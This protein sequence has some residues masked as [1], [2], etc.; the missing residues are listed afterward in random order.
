M[1]MAF[2]IPISLL[3]NDHKIKIKKELTLIETLKPWFNKNNFQKPTEINFYH[4]DTQRNE[5]LLP[6]YKAGEIFGTKIINKRKIYKQVMP[7]T[8]KAELYDYQKKVVEKALEHYNDHGGAFFNVFCA[9]GKTV[10][11][12]HMSSLFSQT[13]GLRT[14][15][16][17][18]LIFIGKSWIGTF[19]NLTNANVYV[20]GETPGPIM[21]HHQV[22]LSMEGR[23]LNIP[24]EVLATIGHFIIDEAHTACT[25]NKVEMLLSVE[26]LFI[27]LLSATAERD[28]GYH[29]MLDMLVGPKKITKISNKPFFVFKIPT[30]Y[31]VEPKTTK[32]GVDWNDLIDQFDELP[33]RNNLIL[34]LVLNN[35][36][37]KI[38]IAFKH[39]SSA[40]RFHSWLGSYLTQHGLKSSLLVG[41]TKSY[42]DANVIVA[43]ISKIGIGFDE[44]E[45]CSNWNGR[46]INMLILPNSI[47][48]NEQVYGRVMRS[49]L[50]LV[51]EFYDKNRN[52]RNQFNKKKK[53]IESRNGKILEL[54]ENQIF[55]WEQIKN[56]V[57]STYI[58]NTNIVVEDDDRTESDLMKESGESDIN[59]TNIS[60]S[61]QDYLNS[62]ATRF[63][64]KM[65]S[66]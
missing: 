27:T 42:E 43:S 60:C 26:P 59:E 40:Q 12:A 44:R 36:H 9:F 53:W 13:H 48:K 64:D 37:Q 56:Q 65:S 39:V 28:D 61:S 58:N 47:L 8:L 2:R 66:K 24:K 6:M 3:T 34:Q 25:K 1:K 54:E 30:S 23:V 18:H 63:A 16:I 31:E 50:A 20:V 17:Y 62:I 21:D 52:I 33:D 11:A 5:I 41:T 55:C 22:I 14:L 35:L 7:F 38:L 29:R 46:R 49:D 15:V 4:I 57:I 32:R 10:I 19:S 45:A 51:V